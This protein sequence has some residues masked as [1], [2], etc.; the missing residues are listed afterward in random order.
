MAEFKE[1]GNEQ[2][3]A[4][5]YASAVELYT[6]GIEQEPTNAALFSNR[7][8]AYLKLESYKKAKLDADMCIQLD[9]KWSKGWWRKGTAQ[10][11]D[12]NYIGARQTFNE[13]LQHCPG[14]E[15]LIAGIER[16]KKYIA[17]LESV[18]GAAEREQHFD[19]NDASKRN[20][21]TT[22]EETTP[23]SSEEAPSD[24]E[25]WPGKAK[26]EIERIKT[27]PN[28]YAVLHVSTEASGAQMKKNYY[29][30]ARMLHP[31]KCQLPGAEDA[32]TSVSQAYDTLT[33]VVKRTLY[34]QFLS[35]TGDDA[36]HPNQTYQEW[37]SRQQ[38]VE[39]PKW[40]NFLLS[41][42][43]CAWVLPILI[44]IILSPLVIVLL[45]LFVLMQLIMLPVRVFMQLFFPEK[46]A[47][48][49]E[50]QEKEIAKMEEQAQD[51][52]FAHV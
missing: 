34:D 4:G 48:M 12:Q 21:E 50:E 10:L 45:V 24:G 7:S 15:N 19:P 8:A 13:G 1:R 26:D 52:M 3:Q 30:L 39:L 28:H 51:R 32:M 29:T 33:N 36:E 40:L 23:K 11:E 2:Y 38:P 49:K 31:D 46:Y 17:A 35:Q 27:A 5:N 42:K 43:G 47:Q 14:D 6:A 16:A 37:E 25:A 20:M 22:T 44:I 41:I 9:P 18:Q